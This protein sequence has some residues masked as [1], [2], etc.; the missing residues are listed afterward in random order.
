MNILDEIEF[1]IKEIGHGW[2]TPNK[3]K[4]LAGA[5]IAL[6]PK[7]SMELGT[8][9]GKG[10]ISLA[11]AHRSIAYGMVYGIDP[12]SAS[13]SAEGQ[14][15][16]ADKKWWAEADHEAIFKI[17]SDNILKFGCQ[18]VCQIIRRRS[19]SYNPPKEMGILVVDA[20]HGEESIKDLRRYCP[21]V[22]V[23]GLVFVDD[24]HWAGSSVER[25]VEML[26]MMGFKEL[27][28]IE[29]KDENFGVFQKVK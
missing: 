27:Y 14:V 24:L 4:I 10:L 6:R 17:A 13:A 8:W 28:R 22:S 20:N 23:G 25:G 18:N 9:A 12:Y 5:V 21:N 11:L 15:S 3:G 19:D 26:P 16:A 1:A 29:N 2:T 7:I